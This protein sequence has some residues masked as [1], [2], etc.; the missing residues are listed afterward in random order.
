MCL[1]DGATLTQ[2]QQFGYC[3]LRAQNILPLTDK[4]FRLLR[5]LAEFP[6]FD[7]GRHECPSYGFSDLWQN[8]VGE[9]C[10]PI[11]Q[12]AP[13]AV[14]DTVSQQPPSSNASSI[15]PLSV[16]PVSTTTTTV[17]TQPGLLPSPAVSLTVV[18]P[19]RYVSTSAG[20]Y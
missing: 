19:R 5:T 11:G 15:P 6:G 20:Q 10:K 12:N 16:S 17:S 7:T 14:P 9:R 2:I 8:F 13:I 1:F 18:P 4:E 3:W